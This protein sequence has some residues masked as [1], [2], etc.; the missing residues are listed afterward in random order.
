ML[1]NT[2]SIAKI[3]NVDHLKPGMQIV[4]Y[5]RLERIFKDLDTQTFQWIKNEFRGSKTT[6]LRRNV[7]CDI[8]IENLKEG[9]TVSTIFDIPKSKKQYHTIY[10]SI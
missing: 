1:E 4:A 6:I 9:D 2:Q 5:L 7:Q 3:S 10:L 8:K